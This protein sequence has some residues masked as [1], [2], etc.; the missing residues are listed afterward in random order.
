MDWI[1]FVKKVL[2][3]ITAVIIVVITGCSIIPAPTS[4]P[5]PTDG[6]TSGSTGPIYPSWTPPQAKQ[7]QLQPDLSTLVA[8]VEPSVVSIN[9]KLT[10][11]NIFGQSTTQEGAGSGW[12]I[13]ASGLIVTNNHV[14]TGAQNILV[15]LNDGRVFSSAQVVADPVSDLAVIKIN[16]TGLP[17]ASLG[18]SSQMKVGMMVGA[19]GNALGQGLSMTAGWISRL[20]ASI[21]ISST[22]QTLYDLIETSTPINPGNSGGP[23]VNTASQVIGITNAKLVATGVTNVGYAIS[24]NNAIPIIQQLVQTGHVVRPYIGV[25]LQTVNAGVAG[26]Y[27]LAVDSGALITNVDANSP[28]SSAGLKP[29]DV[30]VQI[31]N[32]VVG[33]ASQGADALQATQIGKPVKIVYWRGNSQQTVEVT[34]IQNPQA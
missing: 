24:I 3:I 34:P 2:V 8:Q 11:T 15:T 1:S 6:S 27:G 18:D 14:V 12:I 31:N 20:N 17:V 22:N 25:V 21:S 28:A 7:V 32:T 5:T 16:A 30:I 4:S 26:L 23:L 13:D 19:I 29:G 10:S 33:S 9:V